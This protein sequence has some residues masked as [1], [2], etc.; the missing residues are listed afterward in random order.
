[1][2]QQCQI[3]IISESEMI[4][5]LMWLVFALGSIY[6][7]HCVLW[8]DLKCLSEWL[9]ICLSGSFCRVQSVSCWPHWSRHLRYIILLS[10][11]TRQDLTRNCTTTFGTRTGLVSVN[12]PD[13]NWTYRL[14]IN[15]FIFV[16]NLC[17]LFLYL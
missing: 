11:T 14:H 1:M 17:Y 5:M 13:T 9:W 3:D 16:N 2:N 12:N 10:R 4:L 7:S 8:H 15:I 6:I